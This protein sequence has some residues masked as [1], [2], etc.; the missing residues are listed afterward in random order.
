MHIFLIV[1]AVW[2]VIWIAAQVWLHHTEYGHHIA[3]QARA[4]LYIFPLF[5]IFNVIRHALGV[6]SESDKAA[7]EYLGKL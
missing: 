3:W 7:E 5:I 6:K 4:V 2:T 1:T